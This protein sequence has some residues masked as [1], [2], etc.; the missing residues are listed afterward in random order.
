MD[1]PSQRLQKYFPFKIYQKYHLPFKLDSRKAWKML[2]DNRENDDAMI[3]MLVDFMWADKDIENMVNYIDPKTIGDVWDILLGVIS[4]YCVEDIISYVKDDMNYSSTPQDYKDKFDFIQHEIKDKKYK[5]GWVP[6]YET[7]N[8]MYSY[9]KDDKF[10][11][12]RSLFSS[13]K[14]IEGE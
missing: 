2:C 8:K 11:R 7:L 4:R 14:D 12:I 9:M 13:S 3:E 1:F 6:S 5:G 10:K